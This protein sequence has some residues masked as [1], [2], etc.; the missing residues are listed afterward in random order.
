MIN[1]PKIN[2][3]KNLVLPMEGVLVAYSG[4]TD[5]TL[6]LKVARDVLGEKVLAV[7]AKSPLYPACELE[8]AKETAKEIGARHLV[9]ESDELKL[10]GF[11]ENPK[12]RCYICKRELFDRLSRIAKEEGL[13]YIL[14][15]SNASDTT[16]VRPGRQAAC[17]FGVRSV[18]EEAGLSKD[19]VREMSRKLGLPTYNKPSAACLAS[20]FP[21]GKQI[22]VR[23]LKMVEEAEEYIKELGISQVRVRHYGNLCRIEVDKPQIHL[24]LQNQEP[25]AAKLKELGYTYVTL[26]LEGYR[27]G[28][29]NE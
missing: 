10:P 17:E 14:D 22:T 6:V 25:V 23:A 12:N 8:A 5:S 21:Y 7:T 2:R 29:M 4:G 19:E 20:R 3:L 9:I 15:G 16:D 27:T 11:A 18:L 28:S 1:S 13:A 26:D 24:C